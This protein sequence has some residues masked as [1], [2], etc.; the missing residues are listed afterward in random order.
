MILEKNRKKPVEFGVLMIEKYQLPV[1]IPDQ[2]EKASSLSTKN[3]GKTTSKQ[4][5]NTWNGIDL[6]H[7]SKSLKKNGF[8]TFPLLFQI[9]SAASTD[10][11]RIQRALCRVLFSGEEEVMFYSGS[12]Q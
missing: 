4:Q 10:T 11:T 8:K 6:P 3:K 7:R 2:K 9:F 5:K 1:L 12:L